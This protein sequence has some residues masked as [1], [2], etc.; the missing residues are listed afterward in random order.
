MTETTPAAAEPT[1]ALNIAG[2]LSRF[3]WRGDIALALGIT[4]IL[5][6]LILPMPTW[7]LDIGLAIS[8]TLSVLILMT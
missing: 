8:I 7:L 1:E 6:V 5:V 4:C 2:L 3:V